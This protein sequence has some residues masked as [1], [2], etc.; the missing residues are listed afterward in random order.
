MTQNN[1]PLMFSQDPFHNS[2]PQTTSFARRFG[3]DKG[4]KNLG[5]LLLVNTR[6]GIVYMDF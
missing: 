2:Q 6:A 5:F 1:L 3:G 4:I